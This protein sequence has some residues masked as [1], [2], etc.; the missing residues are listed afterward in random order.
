[1][2]CIFGVLNT[3]IL[4]GG[5][6]P[7]AVAQDHQILRWLGTTSAKFQTPDRSLIVNAIWASLLVGWGTFSRLLFLSAAA[8]WLFF[9]AASA[10]LFV[11]RRRFPEKKRPFSMW[12]YPWT[13]LV[14]TVIAFWI[15]LNTAIYSPRE[16]VLGFSIIALGIPLYAISC[17]LETKNENRRD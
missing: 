10:S 3:V 11:I 7:Y 6:I 8:V 15:F 5:R 4:A 17:W 14:F 13:A 9:A 16:T 1:M 2:A 12:G